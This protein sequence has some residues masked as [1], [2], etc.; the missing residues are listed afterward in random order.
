M[1]A[2]CNLDTAASVTLAPSPTPLILPSP[3]SDPALLATPVP[4]QTVTEPPAENV[5]QA[6]V[7]RLIVPVVSFLF[8]FVSDAVVSLWTLA[9]ERGGSLGQ[10]LC[11][12][13]PGG[14]VGLLLFARLR[15]LRR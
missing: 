15:A 3:T 2:G 9:W 5:F 4:A 12:I 13:A 1:L 6:I 7:N 10:V 11:C 14:V 8:T